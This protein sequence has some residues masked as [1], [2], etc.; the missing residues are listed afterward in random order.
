METIMDCQFFIDKFS[1][2]PDE[3][4]CVGFT[5][6]PYDSRKH[7]AYGWCGKRGVF[8]EQGEIIRNLFWLLRLQVAEVNDGDN[9]DYQQATPKARILQALY[10]IKKLQSPQEKVKVIYR[11]VLIDSSVK[12]LRDKE[13]SLQ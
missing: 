9:A 4:W 12:E 6:D 5:E 7:C 13:L 8:S 11:S 1:K 10:D 3:L 2:I